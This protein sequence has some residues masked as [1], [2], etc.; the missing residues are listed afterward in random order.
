MIGVGGVAIPD[1]VNAALTPIDEC[2]GPGSK[3]FTVNGVQYAVRL[4]QFSFEDI[5][6]REDGFVSWPQAPN[7]VLPHIHGVIVAYDAQNSESL[8]LIP[9]LRSKRDNGRLIDI[10]I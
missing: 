1:F 4:L 5:V 10:L 8:R 2:L 9:R 6:I 7:Q 3:A